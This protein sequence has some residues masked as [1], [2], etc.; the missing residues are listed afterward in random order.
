MQKFFSIGLSI[1]LS[2][3]V[4]TGC[5]QL[6]EMIGEGA[7]TVKDGAAAVKDGAEAVKD[8]AEAGVDAVKEGAENVKDAIVGDDPEAKIE[9]E[10]K[11]AAE[12]IEAKDAEKVLEDL[13]KEFE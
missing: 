7:D 8:S 12:A 13:E 2:M 5:P 1:I 6:K 3:I 4:F 9:A 11:K 10:A